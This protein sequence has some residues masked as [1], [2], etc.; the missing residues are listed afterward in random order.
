M[1]TSSLESQVQAWFQAPG[2]I[3]D[4]EPRAFGKWT[5]L[6][7]EVV[8]QQRARSASSVVPSHAPCWTLAVRQ[9]L[10][11]LSPANGLDRGT[12]RIWLPVEYD[13]VSIPAWVRLRRLGVARALALF[14][15]GWVERGVDALLAEALHRRAGRYLPR[16]G[17]HSD[18]AIAG[19]ARALSRA[20]GAAAD[21]SVVQRVPVR[22]GQDRISAWIE[23][24]NAAPDGPRLIRERP[25]RPVRVVQYI[26]SLSPGGAER[27]LCNLSLGLAQAGNECSVRTAYPL[28][29]AQGHYRSLL[30][31]AGIEP[32]VPPPV[33]D[34]LDPRVCWDLVWATPRDLQEL[35][36]SLA[37]DLVSLHP[38]CLHA[39]LDHPNVI[40]G[41]A[42]LAAGVPAV[43]LSTRNWNPTHFPRLY[44]KDIEQVY[45]L[46][47]QSR[48]VH[49]LANSRSGARSYADWLGVPLERFHVVPNGL[50]QEHF[51]VGR[52]VD[53]DH[54][55]G[56]ART[57]A[58]ARLDVGPE[59]PV[60]AVV[61]R[62]SEEKQPELMLEV[63]SL[64]RHHAPGLRVLVAGTGP[65]GPRLRRM[66]AERGLGDVVTFLGRVSDVGLL[67]SAA[68]TLLL[69]SHL[70]GCPNVVLEAQHMGVPVVATSG[71]GTV[72]ALVDGE[73]GFLCG[74]EDAA[75]LTLA[76]C[77]LLDDPALRSR[78][79]A[80]GRSYVDRAFS[81][82]R[83]V[84][85]T[86]L[87]YQEMLGVGGEAQSMVPLVRPDSIR[88]GGAGRGR[89][90]APEPTPRLGIQRDPRLE[91]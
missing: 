65:L 28:D 61:N 47:A 43:L 46:L 26:G 33:R 3:V 48:R 17:R 24:D 32:S 41:L 76:L 34:R 2:L 57:R 80:A 42:A 23:G 37:S 81:L 83:M 64:L 52:D 73:T 9:G 53:P 29:G 40:G 66:V 11:V 4:P 85:N 71:G 63:V 22:S 7:G 6:L 55:D 39:W 74:V 56:G 44:S 12:A 51:E 54:A 8:W 49:W 60:V 20:R 91:P 19:F 1:L 67:L 14:E 88:A 75:G 62:L 27:Q 38:D 25:D 90:G 89:F 79:G 78:M 58:R 45:R 21:P 86:R 35:V 77:R 70:E 18:K 15:D 82:D 72:D 30:S 10:P 16:L 68:D 13:A 5:E 50:F 36:A 87:V 69:T 84:R 59:A 31:R